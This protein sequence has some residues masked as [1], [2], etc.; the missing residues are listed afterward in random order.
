MAVNLDEITDRGNFR[1]KVEAVLRNGRGLGLELTVNNAL[2]TAEQQ[3]A[4][5][6][7]GY[8]KTMRSLHLP[9]PDGKARAV[10]IVD[11]EFGWEAPACVWVMIGRLALTQGCD[12]GGLWGLPPKM[13][14]ELERFLLDGSTRFDPLEWGGKIGWDPAHVQSKGG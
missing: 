4:L 8:S 6:A 11:A 13:R 2:R 3:R 12:W 7:K 1:A 5:V 14:K 10:D 9:G